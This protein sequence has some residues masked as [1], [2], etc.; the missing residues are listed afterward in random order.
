MLEI[1]LQLIVNKLYCFCRF[2]N[3]KVEPLNVAIPSSLIGQNEGHLKFTFYVQF[4][5]GF[6]SKKQLKIAV[7]VRICAADAHYLC[8][9]S[10]TYS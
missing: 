1:M 6:L 7:E 4:S 2:T 3:L 10:L 8:L 5:D 9:V